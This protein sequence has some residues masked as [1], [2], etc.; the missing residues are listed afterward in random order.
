ML[1]A[2]SGWGAVPEVFEETRTTPRW[3]RRAREQLRDLAGP[4]GYAAARRTTVNAHYTDPA[5]ARVI[6]DAVTGLGFTGGRVLEPGCGAGAFI[7]TAPPD[8]QVSM[9]GVELDPVSAAVAAARF[10]QA[11]IRAESFAD[12][13]LPDFFRR[14]GCGLGHELVL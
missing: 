11:T 12:T 9:V 8:L 7:G 14:S 5:Y 10:P 13:D 4:A 1:A 2:W 6:W 3:V